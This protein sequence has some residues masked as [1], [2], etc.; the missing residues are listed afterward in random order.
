MIEGKVI[1]E[2][3]AWA[4]GPD[5]FEGSQ[6]GWT[7]TYLLAHPQRGHFIDSPVMG[8]SYQRPNPGRRHGRFD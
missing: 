4:F 7:F 8:L 6:W 2:E 3:G 1:A 5:E